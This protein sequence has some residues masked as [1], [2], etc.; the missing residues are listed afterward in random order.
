MEFPVRSPKA[1]GTLIGS[2]TFVKI[3][4]NRYLTEEE[5]ARF[6]NAE[7]SEQEEPEL[8][9]QSSAPAGETLPAPETPAVEGSG[10]KSPEPVKEDKGAGSKRE[11]NLPPPPVVHN[12][13]DTLWDV[14]PDPVEEKNNEKSSSRSVKKGETKISGDDD[15]LGIIQPEFGF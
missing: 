1:R 14:P 11:E 8:Q 7:L 5:I 13:T 3:T 10:E 9:E 12:T 6:A 15:D 4:H 2:K